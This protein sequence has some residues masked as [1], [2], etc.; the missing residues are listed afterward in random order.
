M[1]DYLIIQMWFNISIKLKR[2]VEQSKIIIR[3][4]LYKFEND[5]NF[6]YSDYNKDLIDALNFY[7][8]SKKYL[9]FD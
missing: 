4:T 1:V 8:D 9:G 5:K 2:S 3:D 6:N 7:L